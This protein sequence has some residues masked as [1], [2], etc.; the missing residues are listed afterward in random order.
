[1]ALYPPVSSVTLVS[2]LWDWQNNDFLL[3]G[4]AFQMLFS[5][6]SIFR[7]SEW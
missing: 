2:Q 3:M 1:M 4:A 6:P 5:F 7:V